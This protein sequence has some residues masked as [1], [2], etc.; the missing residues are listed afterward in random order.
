VSRDIRDILHGAAQEPGGPPDLGWIRR[1]GRTLVATRIATVA[2]VAVLVAAGAL[3]SVFQI[4]TEDTPPP[5]IEEPAPSPTPG[6]EADVVDVAVCP[7]APYRPTYLPWLDE[8]EEAGEPARVVHGDVEQP[9]AR[10]SWPLDPEALDPG[11]NFEPPVVTLSSIYELEREPGTAE[12]PDVDVMGHEGE[13]VWIG[14]PGIGPVALI[15][16]ETPGPFGAYSLSLG[17]FGMGPYLDVDDAPGEDVDEWMGEVQEALEA[18][19][20]RVADSLVGWD[21]FEARAECADM[22]VPP[23]L[24][25][26]EVAVYFFCAAHTPPLVGVARSVPEGVEPVRAALEAQTAGPTPEERGD[27]LESTLADFDDVALL[28]AFVTDDGTAVVDL[29]GLPDALTPGERSFMPPGF[30]DEVA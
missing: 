28:D 6:D 8:G 24:E 27:G 3:G 25:A 10:A 19:I 22:A 16:R 23:E 17:T 5:I 29:T 18:E 4:P 21:P 11:G 13:M 7:P 14:D 26:D 1:R 12:F 9:S 20:L 30:L 2:G 15:W